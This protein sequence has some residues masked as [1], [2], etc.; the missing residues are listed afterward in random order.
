[1]WGKRPTPAASGYTCQSSSRQ[2]RDVPSAHP[3][4]VK[5]G[6]CVKFWSWNFVSML[7]RESRGVP[8]ECRFLRRWRKRPTQEPALAHVHP[9]LQVLSIYKSV[10]KAAGVPG[11]PMTALGAERHVYLP[12]C[13]CTWLHV[14]APCDPHTSLAHR[15]ARKPACPQCHYSRDCDWACIPLQVHLS[16]ANYR[17]PG[18]E[19][20]LL[21]WS[22]V[23]GLRCII[24]CHHCRSSGS[25]CR[26]VGVNIK[27]ATHAAAL[28]IV[29]S[30]AANKRASVLCTSLGG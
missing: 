4:N 13:M 2:S 18:S 6:R 26:T 11:L 5:T 24:Q 15:M 21:F 7:Q 8:S 17:C 23:D 19:F 20:F 3:S 10:V 22:V 27:S 1:M 29:A 16:L 12:Q 28:D 14:A 30:R 25:E 9:V